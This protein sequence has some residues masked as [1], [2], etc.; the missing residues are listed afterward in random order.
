MCNNLNAFFEEIESKENIYMV[1]YYIVG[2]TATG[3]RFPDSTGR[4]TVLY[5]RVNKILA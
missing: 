2:G 3:F 5:I 4:K 1:W